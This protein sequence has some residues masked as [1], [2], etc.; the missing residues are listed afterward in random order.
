MSSVLYEL[1]KG[2]TY[3]SDYN[4]KTLPLVYDHV[5]YEE[6]ILS[7]KQIADFLKSNKL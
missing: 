5:K 3:L 1:I 4:L 7:V 6:A 2:N